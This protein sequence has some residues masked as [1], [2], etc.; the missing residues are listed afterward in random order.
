MSDWENDDEPQQVA[1]PP[2]LSAAGRKK[3][4]DEDVEDEVKDD[5]EEDDS[6]PEAPKT[7]AVLPPR[8]KKSVKQKIAEKEEEE[9]VRREQGLDESDESGE[10]WDADP[11]AKRRMEREAQLKSDVENA[12]NL[13]G[14]A[15]IGDDALSALRT[16]NPSS[17]EDWESFST[18]LFTELLKSQSTKP[19]FDKHFV[20]HIYRLIASTLRDVDIRKNS[21]ML[22]TYAEEKVKAE[23]EAKKL[24]GQKVKVAAAKPKA[25]GTSSAKNVIDTRAY[26]DE[27]LDDDLDFM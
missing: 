16:A 11:I 2:K 23:K 17:K 5:W 1:P 24:G 12:A 26:G 19:G 20:P 3:F 4:D 7:A 9:R 6:E 21:T 14:T 10:E 27:A 18:S 15:K 13:L 8:K 22:K 25:V